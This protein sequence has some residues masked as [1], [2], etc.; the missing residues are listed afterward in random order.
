LTEQPGPNNHRNDATHTT[1]D[2]GKNRRRLL[3]K[4]ISP[5]GRYTALA[6]LLKASFLLLALAAAV[7]N[8]SQ[9]Y[10]QAP[11]GKVGVCHKTGSATNPYVYQVIDVNAVAAHLKDGDIIGVNSQ[12]DCP[13]TVLATSQAQGSVAICHRTDSATNPYVFQVIDENAVPAHVELG[14]IIGVSSQA[15]CPATALSQSGANAAA[16]GAGATGA[17]VTAA[18][19]AAGANAPVGLPTTGGTPTAPDPL[20][21]LVIA[22]GGLTL[23]VVSKLMGR[24]PA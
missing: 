6:H 9:A 12:A 7:L 5:A 11:K 2:D 23:L 3:M 18:G 14:D 8:V 20:A 4:E 21:S 22:F 10:A 17:G 13:K 19:A 1:Y 16:T 15:D 24:R